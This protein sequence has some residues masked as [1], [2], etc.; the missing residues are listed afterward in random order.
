[1]GDKKSSEA[2]GLNVFWKF[3]ESIRILPLHGSLER[4][5]LLCAFH[6]APTISKCGT[7]ASIAWI[8]DRAGLPTE[9]ARHHIRMLRAD[10]AVV[11]SGRVGRTELFSLSEET[12]ANL[13]QCLA[14]LSESAT[15]PRGASNLI[16]L[17]LDEIALSRRGSR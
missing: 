10:G 4:L 13:D 6:G 14:A 2:V 17:E 11:V 1:M 12:R 5:S 8:A 7:G 15:N 9:I 16:S 3:I